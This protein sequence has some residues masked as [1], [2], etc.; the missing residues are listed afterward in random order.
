MTFDSLHPLL[1][2][3]VK[4]YLGL[5][6]EIPEHLF[7]FLKSINQSY[8]LYD[9]NRELVDRAMKLSGEE[10]FEKNAKLFEE[11]AR[12]RSLINNIKDAIRTISPEQEINDDDILRIGEILTNT[13]KERKEFEK[14][15][16]EARQNAEQSLET[17]K[18]F[19][20][21]ISHEIRTP[22]N[23][24]SGMSGILAETE[25]SET[26]KQYVKAIQSSSKA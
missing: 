15:L 24:I 3:Q 2:R 6:E 11:A 1:K 19:L 25:I 23:A 5:Q 4:K 10:L 18:L 22:I 26:Q 14:Q 16:E 13:V 20:A 8:Q 17:R 7:N 12:Q 21:N 9:S